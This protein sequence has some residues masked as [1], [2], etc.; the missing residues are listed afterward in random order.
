MKEMHL[1]KLKRLFP[2]GVLLIAL[3]GCGQSGPLYLPEENTQPNQT[4]QVTESVANQDTPT[5]ES[6]QD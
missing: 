1:K 4:E 6:K 3:A 2:L 5:T